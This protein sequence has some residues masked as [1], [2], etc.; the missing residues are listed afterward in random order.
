[1]GQFGVGVPHLPCAKHGSWSVR[2]EEACS[3][4]CRLRLVI[5]RGLLYEC[6]NHP[7]HPRDMEEPESDS[8]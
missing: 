3:R 8:L 4:P 7:D 1:M 2:G 6:I 5:E